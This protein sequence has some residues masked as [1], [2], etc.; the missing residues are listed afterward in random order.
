MRDFVIQTCD[1]IEI[2]KAEKEVYRKYWLELCDK[3]LAEIDKDGWCR[4]SMT[5]EEALEMKKIF[6]NLK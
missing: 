2:L 5:R 4:L 1:E 3:I 6:E